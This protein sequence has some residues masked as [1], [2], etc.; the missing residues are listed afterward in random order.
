MKKLS[1]ALATS[2]IAFSGFSA[3]A[4]EVKL[5]GAT[6]FQVG[7]RNQKGLGTDKNVTQNQKNIAFY[8]QAYVTT[9]VRNTTESGFIYGADIT[10]RVT[11]KDKAKAGTNGSCLFTEANY[12]RVELGSRQDAPSMMSQSAFNIAMGTG[13]DWQRY[14]N[15]N[16]K[17][18]DGK[19]LYNGDVSFYDAV[20]SGFSSGPEQ[21]R[22]ATYY[23][24]K[25]HGFQVGVSYSPDTANTGDNERIDG[26]KG[27]SEQTFYDKTSNFDKVKAKVAVRDLVGAG[28]TYEHNIAD[29]VDIKLGAGVEAG[30]TTAKDEA[31]N[32]LKLSDYRIYNVGA[33][34][35]YGNWSFAGSYADSG[36]S[37]TSTK[38]HYDKRQTRYYTGGV[39]Y[40]QG[41]MG[42]SLIYYHNDKLM[43]KMDAITLGTQY[44]L[45]PGLMPYFEVTSFKVKNRG[46]DMSTQTSPKPVKKKISGMACMFGAR[47]TF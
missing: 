32:K 5:Q 39:A 11:V 40:N 23:T 1:L 46:Y 14:V 10:L 7:Y 13:D 30:K 22:T 9:D 15:L 41:P 24:P 18:Y 33:V 27:V 29:G 47:V 20:Y 38:Y 8:N 25:M 4:M 34:V 12:G 42:L 31:G 3:L 17:L 6:D 36:K 28:V 37:M 19:G 21:V 26:T 43:N 45:A 44:K 35:S 16:P 2:I